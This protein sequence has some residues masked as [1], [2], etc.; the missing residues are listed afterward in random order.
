MRSYH[1]T[2]F[3]GDPSTG[4]RKYRRVSQF[5]A[6]MYNHTNSWQTTLCSVFTLAVKATVLL[7]QEELYVI[8][9]PGPAEMMDA[10][11][12]HHSNISGGTDMTTK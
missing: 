6:K 1:G 11:A 3:I 12:I 9:L 7:N 5:V 8:V 10:N 4:V 2:A